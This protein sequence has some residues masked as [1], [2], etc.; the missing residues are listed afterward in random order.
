[1][2]VLALI[3]SVVAITVIVYDFVQRKRELGLYNEQKE[4]LESTM[5]ALSDTHNRVVEKQ[6]LVLDRIETLELKVSGLQNA[7]PNRRL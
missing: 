7:T 4:L 6:V 1:M 3:L 5:K 2:D